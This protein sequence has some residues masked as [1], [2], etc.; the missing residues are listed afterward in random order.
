MS[1]TTH[2]RNQRYSQSVPSKHIHMYMTV[3]QRAQVRNWEHEAKKTNL[4]D[5]EGIDLPA[6]GK[7]P[8]EYYW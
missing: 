8:Y 7:K 5:I 2:H 6:H 3:P 4:E 1:R